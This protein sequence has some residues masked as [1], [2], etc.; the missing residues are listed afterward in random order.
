MINFVSYTP[1]SVYWF[2]YNVVS[3]VIRF[4]PFLASFSNKDDITTHEREN[5]TAPSFPPDHA[6]TLDPI[7]II[8][9]MAVSNSQETSRHASPITIQK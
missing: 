3:Y 8:Q 1:T 4:Q 9:Q 7:I 6:K 2:D 5:I